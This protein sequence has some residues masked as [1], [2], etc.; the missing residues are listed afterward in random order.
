MILDPGWSAR[1]LISFKPVDGP[2]FNKRKSL[3]IR[4]KSWANVRSALEKNTASCIDCID[5]NRLSLV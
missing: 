1:K 2:L 4:I 3:A 5:S